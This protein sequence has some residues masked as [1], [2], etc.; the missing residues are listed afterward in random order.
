VNKR[1]M[2]ACL[3]LVILV[4][5]YAAAVDARSIVGQPTTTIFVF[6]YAL[7]AAGLAFMVGRASREP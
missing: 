4:A 3:A 6:L 5:W 1:R 7:M 2:T